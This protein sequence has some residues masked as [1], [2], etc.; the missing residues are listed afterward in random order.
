MPHQWTQGNL[1]VH[2][3]CAVCDG[4]CGSVRRLQ[5]FYCL[6]CHATVS[7]LAVLSPIHSVRDAMRYHNA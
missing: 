1:P 3:K 2:A 4:T 6:W 5:D 7:S